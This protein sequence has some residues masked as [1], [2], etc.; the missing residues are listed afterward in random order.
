MEGQTFPQNA[1]QLQPHDG[2][3]QKQQ[4]QEPQRGKEQSL[5][6]K[7]ATL[8]AIW[9]SY[10][11]LIRRK[12]DRRSE[13][14]L[15]QR[16]FVL[17]QFLGQFINASL[18]NHGNIFIGEMRNISNELSQE[19]M[20]NLDMVTRGVSEEDATRSL[21]DYILR[22]RGWRLLYTVDR[23]GL[24]GVVQRQDLCEVLL[25]LLPYCLHMKPNSP[26]SMTSS[27]INTQQPESNEAETASKA[28]TLR[29]WQILSDT[30][31]TSVP[32]NSCFQLV[33]KTSRLKQLGCH[34]TQVRKLRK[35]ASTASYMDM[36]RRGSSSKAKMS[37]TGFGI[38]KSPSKDGIRGVVGAGRVSKKRMTRSTPSKRS[39]KVIQS[40]T[41]EE[42]QNSLHHT[43]QRHHS[44]SDER[45]RSRQ[46]PRFKRGFR[47]THMWTPTPINR[48]EDSDTDDEYLGHMVN[49]DSSSTSA[50][51]SVTGFHVV[52]IILRLLR[53]L[54][55]LDMGPYGY[56]RGRALSA[57]IL[58]HLLYLFSQFRQPGLKA[59]EL[60]S[61]AK[62]ELWLD[63]HHSQSDKDFF[64]KSSTD[65]PVVDSGQSGN[66]NSRDGVEEY[67]HV[68]DSSAKADATGH[69]SDDFDSYETQTEE[70][71]E[72]VPWHGASKMLVLRQL[73]R[74]ILTL[75]GIVATQQN[76]VRILINLRVVDI[77]LDLDILDSLIP[78]Y[79]W[80][81]P[82][83]TDRVPNSPGHTHSDASFSLEATVAMETVCGLLQLLQTIYTNLP[84]NPSCVSDANHLVSKLTK[85][86]VSKRIKRLIKVAEI[87]NYFI[88][89]TQL[90]SSAS[91][92][93]EQDLCSSLED[94]R[95]TTKDSS[96]LI[97]EDSIT[98]IEAV[99]IHV[100][101]TVPGN[102]L[103]A[104]VCEIDKSLDYDSIVTG[105]EV[106][107][108]ETC[109]KPIKI[110]FQNDAQSFGKEE[111]LKLNMQD[112]NICKN[113]SGNIKS[114]NLSY[115]AQDSAT[116][117]VFVTNYEYISDPSSDAV[118]CMGYLIT[119][120][121]GIKVNYIHSM[122]CLKQRHRNCEY[123]IYYDHHHDILGTPFYTSNRALHEEE[124]T[125]EEANADLDQ[126]MG[127]FKAFSYN[128]QSQR[129]GSGL[130]DHQAQPRCIVAE[131]VSILLESMAEVSQK[132]SQVHIISTL[133]SVGVC[134]CLQPE[135]VVTPVVAQL[136]SFTPAVRSFALDTLTT[137]LLDQFLGAQE[138]TPGSYSK[139]QRT[140]L[141]LQG[142]QSYSKHMSQP[143][144]PSG[145]AEWMEYQQQE[146]G[147]R[148]GGTEDSSRC[149]HCYLEGSSPLLAGLPSNLDSGFASCQVEELRRQRMLDR[150]RCLRVMGR[151]VVGRD[152]SLAMSCAKHLMTLA[153]RGNKEI[154]EELFFGVYLHVLHMKVALPGRKEDTAGRK[155]DLLSSTDTSLF[156]GA[157]NK[158]IISKDVTNDTAINDFYSQ[159]IM[160]SSLDSLSNEPFTAS[161][162]AMSGG[163]L[164]STDE[165][166]GEGY[167]SSHIMLL[168]VSA[169]PY[170]LQVD[171]VMSIFLAR[172]GLVKLTHLLEY[173]ELR[174]P[175]MSVFEALVMIDERRLSDTHQQG[176]PSPLISMSCEQSTYEGG[177]VIQTFIDTVASRTCTVTATLQQ[178]SMQK[179]KAE[180]AAAAVIAEGSRLSNVGRDKN[181][182][183]L[184]EATPP[185]EGSEFL[186]MYKT[187]MRTVQESLRVSDTDSGTSPK[188]STLYTHPEVEVTIE[189]D[190]A[191]GDMAET[192]PVLLDM[193][194]TCA[195]LCM[196]SRTF[197]VFFR[198]SPCLYVVQE[199]L[200]LALSL[201]GEMSGGRTEVSCHGSGPVSGPTTEPG[202]PIDF[203][204]GGATR[205]W[206]GSNKVNSSV[207]RGQGRSHTVSEAS[208]EALAPEE[209]ELEHCVLMSHQARLEFIEAVMMVCFSCRT[210]SPSQKRGHEDDLWMRLSS[211]LQ[212]CIYLEPSKLS[213]VFQ[214]LLNVALPRCPSVLEY[215]YAQIIS[216][217]N[218]KEKEDI[219]DE[220]EVKQLL[221]A[222]L[223]EDGDTIYT[224]Q[225]YDGD[226][227]CSVAFDWKTGLEY[228]LQHRAARLSNTSSGFGC[229]CFPAAFRLLVELL[230]ACHRDAG[231]GVI[232]HQV[233]L[234]L[235][236][237]LRSSRRAVRAVC[238]EGLLGVLV[239]GFRE[240]LI[241]H[242]Q[243]SQQ[244]TLQEIILSLVQVIAQREISSS[245]LRQF[246]RLFQDNKQT[247]DCLLS[248]LLSV[249]EKHPVSPNSW[250]MFPAKTLMSSDNMVGSTDEAAYELLQLRSAHPS[251]KQC[252]IFVLPEESRDNQGEQ[253]V[254]HHAAVEMDV[255]GIQW[256]PWSMGFT[257]AFWLSV[258]RYHC[259]CAKCSKMPSTSGCA[260][261]GY[262]PLSETEKGNK[263]SCPIHRV[264]SNE[265]SLVVAIGNKEKMFEVWVHP[266]SASLICKLT[267]GIEEITLLK[268]VNFEGLL[269]P[270]LWHMVSIS[271]K[272][273]LEGS[274]FVGKMTLV[275]DGWLQKE[276]ILD[277]PASGRRPLRKFPFLC[278]G[279]ARKAPAKLYTGTWRLGTVRVFRDTVLSGDW[280]SHLYSLGPNHDGV[281]KCDAGEQPACHTHT[282]PMLKQAL[283][284]SHLSWDVLVGTAQVPDLD[285]ARA[286]QVLVYKI[287]QPEVFSTFVIPM[288]AST[289]PSMN[290]DLGLVPMSGSDLMTQKPQVWSTRLRGRIKVRHTNTL[291]KAAGCIGGVETFLFLV[292]KVF[293]DCMKVVN[294]GGSLTEAE[295]LQSK[296]TSILFTLVHRYPS[297][298]QAFQDIRG[299]AMLAKVFTSSKSIVGFHL[300]KVLLDACTSESLF[301]SV[302]GSPHP[303]LRTQ[304]EAVIRDMNVLT[305]LLLN[306]RIWLRAT[307]E[308]RAILVSAIDSVV[309]K[310]NPHREFNLRQMQAGNV[311][312]KIFSIYLERIQD[313]QPSLSVNV[314]ILAAKVI[315]SLLGSPPDLH[316]MMA[317]MD[318]LL[319]VHP[320]ASGYISFNAEAFYFK[321]WWDGSYKSNAGSNYFNLALK[322]YSKQLTPRSAEHGKRVEKTSDS[323][324]T[325]S[326]SQNIDSSLEDKPRRGGL[327][328][329]RPYLSSTSHTEDY[330]E[331]D[332]NG[333]ERGEN[334]FK[335]PP[336]KPAQR[337]IEQ[338]PDMD[339]DHEEE[340][341]T[342]LAKRPL[343]QSG[344]QNPP[345]TFT[346][347]SSQLQRSLDLSSSSGETSAKE[348]RL[349]SR[350][351]M[352]DVGMGKAGLKSAEMDKE[353]VRKES[354]ESSSDKGN[355][356]KN[357]L[358]R[359]LFEEGMHAEDAD[360]ESMR[361][362]IDGILEDS[363]DDKELKKGK[364]SESFKDT[365]LDGFEA[366]M[367]YD[368]AVNGAGSTTS[369]DEADEQGL[370]RLCVN[371]LEHLTEIVMEFPESSLDNVFSKVVS[372][373]SML[374]LAKN[375]SADVRLAVIKLLGAY[376]YRAPS[377][378]IDAFIKM[379]GFYLL[380]NQ[381]RSFPV[382]SSH[383]EAAI[384][385]L[386]R[387]EFV[388]D[389]NFI[390]GDLGELTQV[391]Q[392]APILILSLIDGTATDPDLCKNA[393]AFLAQM[394]QASQ[395]MST[396][397]LDLG[398]TE[399]MCNLASNIQRRNIVEP[400][401][402]EEQLTLALL[403]DV[404]H[405]LFLTAVNEF[406][407]AGPIHASNCDEMF[408][409]LRA[410][411]D[412]EFGEQMDGSKKRA[413]RARALQI[414]LVVK[415]FAFVEKRS[416]DTTQQSWLS[417]SNGA[418]SL[419]W[420]HQRP[421]LY[422]STV[423]SAPF[424][425]S[426]KQPN[427]GSLRQ[428][429]FMNSTYSPQFAAASTTALSYQT[430]G[431]AYNQYSLSRQR[432]LSSSDMMGFLA[433]LMPESSQDAASGI[434]GVDSGL[435]SSSSPNIP[436]RPSGVS[437]SSS[438]LG[439][440]LGR[441]RR[442]SY[443]PVSQS[444]L[445]D[446]FRKIL[447]TATDLAIM[448]PR[449]ERIRQVKHRTL[450]YFSEHQTPSLDD[451]YLK[452]LFEMV[453][454]FYQ[455]SLI[456]D[457]SS[458]KNRNPIMHGARDVLK[459]QF[460]RLLLCLM[461]PKLDFD[462]RT[463]TVEFLM[464]EPRGPDAIKSVIVDKRV[465]VELS[466]YLYDLL[467][468]W[469]DWLNS[470][471]REAG[472]SLVQ[473]MRFA[474]FTINSPDNQL[475]QSQVNALVEDKKLIDAKYRK[476]M[477]AW[478]QKR[479][480]GSSRITQKFEP[481][482]RRVTEQAMAV[483]QDV[484]RLQIEERK[485]LVDHIKRGMTEEIQLKK[486]WQELVTSLT[487][488]RGVW[489]HASSYPQ[490]WLLDPT[491]GP[492]R[493]RRKLQR[494]HLG[495]EAKFLQP[496]HQHKTDAEK[497]DPP[498]VFLF[499]DDHQ[500]SDSAALIYRL[501]TNE[502]IQH[503]CR[504]T[505]VSPANESKGEL[506]VGEVS[507]FFVA[508]GAITGGK[509][510]QMLLGNLDQLSITWPHTDIRELHKRWYQLQDLGLEIFLIS[511][512]TCLLAFESTQD[513]DELHNILRSQL[514]LPNVITVETLQ[515]VQQAWLEGEVTNYDYLIHLNKLAGRSYAD[516]MQYPVFPFILRDYHSPTLNLTDQRI[517]R[518]LKKPIAVQ[519]K[520]KEQRYKDNYE[521][522]CQEAGRPNSDDEMMMKVP[523]FHYGSHYSNSGTVL[524]YLV[525]LPPF[526]NMF[527][528]FQDQSFDI[529]DRTFHSLGTSWRLSSFE[530]STD[531]KELI[532]E[533]FF[534]PEMF[535]NS[536]G[537]DFGVRQNGEPVNDVRL[538]AWCDGD[539]RLFV[540]IHRQ[541]LESAY[542]TAHLNHWLDLVFGYKQK[543][544]EAIRAINVFHPSTYFGVD[545]SQ[546]KDPVKRHALLTMIKT[547]G[548]TPKQLFRNPH[549]YGNHNQIQFALQR[550]E[551]IKSSA[552]VRRPVPNVSGLQWGLYVGSP[553]LPPPVCV[554]LMQNSDL[555][556][557]TSPSAAGAASSVS[558]S[559]R[560]PAVITRLVP[561]PT[562]QVF[563]V[564]SN[565]N[566]LLLHGKQRGESG[567]ESNANMLLLHGK[568]RGESGCNA[569]MLLLHGKQRDMAVKS[570]DVMW[571]GVVTWGYHD[572]L[573]RIRSYHDK[574]LINFLPQPFFG[575]VTCVE[576]VPDCRLLFTA[577]S[578]GVIVVH[579]MTHN[580]S[581]P[582]CLQVRGVKKVL[583]GHS[584]GITCLVVC[585][586]FS[587][588]VSGS[589]DGTY[590]VWDLNHLT[591][592][593]SVCPGIHE[594]QGGEEFQACQESSHPV[595]A[596]GVSETMGEIASVIKTGPKSCQLHLH[597]ING[598]PVVM[599]EL[600]SDV[601]LCL[602]YSAA[603][604]GRSV[605]VVATGMQSGAIRLW[606]SWDLTPLRDLNR[607][608]PMPSPVISV[609]FSADSQYLLASGAD[610]SITLWDRDKRG[611]RAHADRFIP[612][613]SRYVDK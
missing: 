317:V 239:D 223:D 132:S 510:T 440:L 313:G 443:T 195:K 236:Q 421:S 374:V 415:I 254:W 125:N 594:P 308:V 526:T 18:E 436:R 63:N 463:A 350:Y 111:S 265:S 228:S 261:R 27:T 242:P 260:D 516:L 257:L 282:H 12:T 259:C 101:K 65:Q 191:F 571:A 330:E 61:I 572:N 179:E 418:G 575:T 268:D 403:I 596:L 297:L 307:D 483:T 286:S 367:S 287:S 160:Q 139:S 194:R 225:G 46:Q 519:D 256:P 7:M 271:Y 536:E 389:D 119:T 392:A 301:K 10:A 85:P 553:D 535:I 163:D 304:S 494:G 560:N 226:T 165:G 8:S 459:A 196:N 303:V 476:E 432:A 489:Y 488:E 290:T 3:Q 246:L 202:S 126:S 106:N 208:Q 448:Y 523:P 110:R 295:H 240:V 180:A 599:Q 429:S 77:L 109:S 164:S 205:F 506:L 193:W 219:A 91:D 451:R 289:G 221:Q 299:Y 66:K 561:L 584:A 469:R 168:C 593:R 145:A 324:L 387:Q 555:A 40:D 154:K 71:V 564:E 413:D 292:A 406:S 497:L 399:T 137:I 244:Q 19:F 281:G 167:V 44:Q 454:R 198:D 417:S 206:Q 72:S 447:V 319:L 144:E 133:G 316:L 272:D 78:Q 362:S 96:Q 199:T 104:Q 169:L 76:G 255:Q 97:M 582:S 64:S 521:F 562:G 57:T 183:L 103:Q 423:S 509:C 102:E 93:Y 222:G 55:E 274:T 512:R 386:L 34:S 430:S 51:T 79:E 150:W 498:L 38:G 337:V 433:D 452:H 558:T 398:L 559:S 612:V 470:A 425:S 130:S 170:L 437:R 511:G 457:M 517:Y 541:A 1:T 485:K 309:S 127:S 592:T 422:R 395:T 520:T 363:G 155:E 54:G 314:S 58:P 500:M 262:K 335:F 162:P 604:E 529:P 185:T 431:T 149:V 14:K 531:V 227:E 258:D 539:A 173:H 134:C 445:L 340:S 581:K 157:E 105:K 385:I 67:G 188:D 578:A 13:L 419:E 465:G 161:D 491:E 427:P 390:V 210:I 288:S 428:H 533:F 345:L 310:D 238:S 341:D 605:N 21:E 232:L 285:L 201:L 128:T 296:A 186:D 338:S 475:T 83:A 405:I 42:E 359:Q 598:R 351:H 450:N 455:H 336:L 68:W 583:S 368:S 247:T 464:A 585:P 530:S 136:T 6:D 356:K 580:S 441:K 264:G 394:L 138:D 47:V 378:L 59:A 156:L 442:V 400:S 62:T 174:A 115:P 140:S 513:R 352:K 544:E 122:K 492:G 518:N 176:G 235:L 159:N 294:E 505:A 504:C 108:S 471:Q 477:E 53:S 414:S 216:M 36:G 507:I 26:H 366:G 241:A 237:T 116:K 142:K 424:Y 50:L 574:P 438:L 579:T 146:S 197:R 151:L 608:V 121:K 212:S 143:S 60:N 449:E 263:A 565:A 250:A 251:S 435:G 550:D 211:A 439:N 98:N 458:R 89:K 32:L 473:I 588:L 556:K 376:L 528:N 322:V 279:D 29:H 532:P 342:V 69:K 371:L 576:S 329:Q 397:L 218:L 495:I 496:R 613:V 323:V 305:Q 35:V 118:R 369:H 402:E 315:R 231:R 404:Q 24:K 382:H 43:E 266:K 546:I 334:V 515:T 468:A 365:D 293:E 611:L 182:Q 203:G 291:E 166:Y 302:S 87:R 158:E 56:I 361:D 312:N 606:S 339:A 601:I 33:S 311:I 393:L 252:S 373:K 545:A 503:T 278:V 230:V 23:M 534:L 75:S 332:G 462:F 569:N 213:A 412:Q 543:G 190:A 86:E 113:E 112:Y 484:T 117:S 610:G 587:V 466:F 522:L 52:R 328:R 426:P 346:A 321:L 94:H 566:M 381:L 331:T 343:S 490:G 501:Y 600:T 597:S 460:T 508:D 603:P 234:R 589:E 344:S 479:E 284:T 377:T 92:L 474:G 114:F 30:Y 88:D 95:S 187:H 306:W 31:N 90:S 25:Y 129:R 245:E 456:K 407:W 383:V 273:V 123:G 100:D 554:D 181:S 360:N 189:T 229:P 178:I 409:L 372:P 396:L 538:P 135:R 563:G 514:E 480:A 20:R 215:S 444:E 280:W 472:F 11:Q 15:Q 348:G 172:R 192:L 267:S 384:S 416:E 184:M 333:G 107:K 217:L 548:Q 148:L 370:M 481:V 358:R 220:D 595:T 542:V 28:E 527:L 420:S 298:S 547:Y 327:V 152:Q 275:L 5:P 45:N 49:C 74:A 434:Q 549:P 224:E 318:F 446:R 410:L 320:A 204:G 277:H 551:R 99:N 22:G 607:D 270:D 73:V 326:S 48:E 482:R 567:V 502:K 249:I 349:K 84:F 37:T 609:A 570:T 131:L 355:Q 171:K 16:R 364:L 354:G 375:P 233:A 39:L 586:A 461:S 200:V 41:E 453:Y 124:T 80:N 300:L 209:E 537:F 82:T 573:I 9:E 411:E 524:H 408:T 269:T 243:D 499:E 467:A 4:R 353:A 70:E 590:V 248:T 486:Q 577:G 602:S 380:A 283:G 388:F 401:P 325:F 81:T 214:M 253:A 357:S 347:P 276:V 177:G 391:Q 591:Y 557:M 147:I 540:L 478:F 141:N 552:Y 17:D 493:V 525:R 568:Q 207:G 175:V 153:V 2:Q 487:H 379:D 120:L